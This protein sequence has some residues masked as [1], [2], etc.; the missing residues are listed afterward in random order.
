[1]FH[2]CYRK[3]FFSIGFNITLALPVAAYTFTPILSATSPGCEAV[4]E[5]LRQC[6]P[7][8]PG[9]EEERYFQ[10]AFN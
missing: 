8:F 3:P 6:L 9:Q 7:K 5:F 2:F 10:C 1:M 4:N